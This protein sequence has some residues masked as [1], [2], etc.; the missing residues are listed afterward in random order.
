[1]ESQE[2]IVMKWLFLAFTAALLVACIWYIIAL[3]RAGRPLPPGLSAQMLFTA[4]LA[5]LAASHLVDGTV[6]PVLICVGALLGVVA[7]IGMW[8]NAKRHL[9]D[10]GLTKPNTTDGATDQNRNSQL[11]RAG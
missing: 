9:I 1:M 10:V 8:R 6:K 3:R 11:N 5:T 4:S 2:L 7:G